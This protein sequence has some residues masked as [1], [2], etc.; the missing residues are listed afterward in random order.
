MPT[1][2]LFKKDIT[3][4]CEYCEFGSDSADGQM[5]ECQKNGIVSP[6]FRCSKFKYSPIRRTPRQSPKLPKLNPEDFTL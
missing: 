3:P 5:V 2:R 6:Y 1:T 4:A